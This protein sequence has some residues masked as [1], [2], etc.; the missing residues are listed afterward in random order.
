MR[1]RIILQQHDGLQRRVVPCMPMLHAVDGFLGD[2]LCP[3]RPRG[4]RQYKGVLGYLSRYGI[5]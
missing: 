1:M 5:R 4:L 3:V 2:R